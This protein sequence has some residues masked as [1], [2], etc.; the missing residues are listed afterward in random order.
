MKPI[1]KEKGIQRISIIIILLARF[2]QYRLVDSYR[3]YFVSLTKTAKIITLSER[4][5]NAIMYS[6][7]AAILLEQ[8]QKFSFMITLRHEVE[9]HCVLIDKHTKSHNT[10]LCKERHNSSRYPQGATS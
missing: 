3:N 5:I 2:Q 1:N 9:L 6:D 7:F 4:N 8:A 10:F